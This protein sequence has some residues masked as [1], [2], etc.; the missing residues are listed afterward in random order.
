MKVL[1]LGNVSDGQTGIYIAESFKKIASDVIATDIRKIIRDCGFEEGQKIIIDEVKNCA[2]KPDLIVVLKGL[3]MSEET[4]AIVKKA[5]PQATFVNWFFD[6][7]LGDKPLWECEEYFN[8]L[9][10]YDFY[11][12]SLKGVA[13]K[14]N[15]LGFDNAVYLDEA[16]HPRLNKEEYLNHFQEQKY[17]EDISFIGSLGY[18]K[19]HPKRIKILDKLAQEGFKMK[20]WGPVICEWKYISPELRYYHQQQSVINLDHSKVCQ[21]SL[22]NIGVDQD[23][24]LEL[25]HSA[26][27]YRV[28]CCGGLY[29]VNGTKG[30]GNMFKINKRG[31]MPTGE[32]DLVVYYDETHLIDVVDF[33]LDNEDIRI[34][35]AKNGQKTVL[36]KHTFVHRVKEMQEI[37]K[38]KVKESE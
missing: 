25:G 34:R 26:R 3:E 17:G 1:I 19:Q 10:L 21:A 37:I 6:K 11:F 27:L 13:T 2:I 23:T 32:E 28:M 38:N 30:L 15:E 20:I 24:A 22:I 14:M 5:H 35:I 12:C 8:T 7:Y 31:E 29:L 33:L 16:C 9:K 36:D 4:T 18:I